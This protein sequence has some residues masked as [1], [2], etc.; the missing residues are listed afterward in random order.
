MSM[1]SVSSPRRVYCRNGV[2]HTLYAGETFGT[3]EESKIV[4]SAELLVRIIGLGDGTIQVTQRKRG[5][6]GVTEVW[7]KV[8]V[9]CNAR[10]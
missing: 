6:K 7:G 3:K 9:P 8:R 1:K 4:P 5:Q 10:S 2:T